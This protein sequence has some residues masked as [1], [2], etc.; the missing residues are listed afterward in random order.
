MGRLSQICS[1]YSEIMFEV[2]YDGEFFYI[3]MCVSFQKYTISLLG[4]EESYSIVSPLVIYVCTITKGDN[5]IL[6]KLNNKGTKEV[7]YMDDVFLLIIRKLHSTLSDLMESA[8]ANLLKYPKNN[9]L[10]LIRQKLN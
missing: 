1:L 6:F 3:R 4:N 9:G 5:E 10:S 7:D 2:L 8:L